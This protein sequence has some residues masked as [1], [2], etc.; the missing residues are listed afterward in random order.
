[1]RS[2]LL[3]ATTL[4][5]LINLPLIKGQT[6]IPQAQAMFIYNFTRLIDWPE[7]S[8]DFIIGVIG[9]NEVFNALNSY[10][11]GK[12]VGLQNISVKQFK[13]ITD[14]TPCNILFIGFSRTKNIPEILKI[15]GDNNTLIITEKTGAIQ[16]GAAINFVIIGDKLKFEIKI[17]NATKYG[18]KVS[19]KL[20]EMAVKTY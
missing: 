6:D 17:D 1:M 7:K 15:I 2:R 13:E 5:F 11:Q 4:F 12:K 10:T 20:A 14:I 8:G 16:M 3:L 19:S 9:S 18:L